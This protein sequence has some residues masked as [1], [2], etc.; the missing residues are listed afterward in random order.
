M[1]LFT[2]N[3]YATGKA[4]SIKFIPT[5]NTYRLMADRQ[6]GF[7]GMA[8]WMD[9]IKNSKDDSGQRKRLAEIEISLEE[10]KRKMQKLTSMWMDGT[11]DEGIYESAMKELKSKTKT[12][13]A[14]KTKI[15]MELSRD[16]SAF[17]WVKLNMKFRGDALT[18]GEYEQL[19]NSMIKRIVIYED[20]IE[21]KTIYN[22]VSIPRQRIWCHN[23]CLNYTLQ[24]KAG[25]AAV[26]YY[27]GKANSKPA[28]SRAYFCA[29][30]L[31]SLEVYVEK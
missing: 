9:I 17:D 11:M 5:K 16:T 10:M 2:A 29:A 12:A 13:E 28:S 6:H 31:G 3:I 4:R 19:A 25:K 7:N 24:M 20:F 18:N 26:Y 1:K 8:V 15:D 23:L 21:V 27:K 22:D 14:E 30:V